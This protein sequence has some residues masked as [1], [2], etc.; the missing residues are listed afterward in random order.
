MKKAKYKKLILTIS[1]LQLLLTLAIIGWNYMKYEK[2][3]MVR[4][5]TF[6]NSYKFPKIYTPTVLNVVVIGL[7]LLALLQVTLI[8]VTK[9]FNSII[10]LNILFIAAS[11][12][13][14]ITYN[15]NR[16]F[17]YYYFVTYL[18][19]VNSLQALKM[20]LYNFDKK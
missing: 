4:H 9:K 7:I 6:W 20:C 14:V 8:V 10:I 3:G 2:M 13:Y 1:T 15:V 19:M 16:E 18:I 17:I 11:I 12:Y 5:I